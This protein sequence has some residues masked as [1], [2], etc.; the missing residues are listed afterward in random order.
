[1]TPHHPD[2][3]PPSGDVLLVGQLRRCAS[4]SFDELG[5]AVP[6]CQKLVL[7]VGSKEAWRE[8]GPV[9][10]RPEAV[11]GLREMMTGRCRVAPGIDS[12]EE[13][14]KAGSYDVGDFHV[15]KSSVPYAAGDSGNDDVAPGTLV[16]PGR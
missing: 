8:A 12:A 1:M 6:E 5:E 3:T 4:G 15:C 14:A 2:D 13:H 7:L 10:R 11:A 9:Q 16:W